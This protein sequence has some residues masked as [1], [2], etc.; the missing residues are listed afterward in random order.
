[1]QTINISSGL[2]LFVK[3]IFPIMSLGIFLPFLLWLFTS[4]S[5]DYAGTLPLA[6]VRLLI[7]SFLVSLLLLLRF[8]LM[9]LMRVEVDATHIYVSDYFKTARYTFESVERIDDQVILLFRVP[10]IRLKAAGVFKQNIYFWAG[11]TFQEVIDEFPEFAK[12]I[13]KK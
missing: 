5:V 13:E 12:I 8:T 1:M 3:F 6:V 2:T 10:V 9:R 7:V 4:D 11:S